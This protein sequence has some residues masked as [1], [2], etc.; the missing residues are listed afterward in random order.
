MGKTP[1]HFLDLYA[2]RKAYDNDRAAN[3]GFKSA[4]H[5]RENSS[6]HS[7]ITTE[8][9]LTRDLYMKSL[10]ESLAAACEYVAKDRAARAVPSLANEQST[11]LRNNLDAQC[12]QFELVME[13]NSKLL[14]ALSKG[15]KGGGGCGSSGSS[16]GKKMAV[17]Q[18]TAVAHAKAA[19]VAAV[20]VT[21]VRA[22]ETP[23]S[24]R[25]NSAQIATNG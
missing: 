2:L 11:L 12:K 25:K 17:L 21:V 13:K 15:G 23:P 24:E 1:T 20:A 4:A 22:A 6:G 8:C 7:V 18:T 16:G 10:E 5:V 3:S 19:A 14:M 9:D